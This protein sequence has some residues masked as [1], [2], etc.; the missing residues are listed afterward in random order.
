[1]VG[2][3]S[4]FDVCPNLGANKLAAPFLLVIQHDVAKMLD[5]RIVVPLVDATSRRLLERADP[6]VTISDRKFAAVFAQMRA[7]PVADLGAP[8]A[9]LKSQH[10]EFIQACDFLI[11]GY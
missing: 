2:T 4:Q 6:I 10:L 8:V 5:T 1:M 11:S 3:L 9:S 7:L